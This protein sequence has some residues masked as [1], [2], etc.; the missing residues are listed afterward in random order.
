MI[1]G[2]TL[3]MNN[4]ALSSHF[5]TDSSQGPLVFLLEVKIKF[6]LSKASIK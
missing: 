6:L 2:P 5:Q 4:A 1:M 3:A